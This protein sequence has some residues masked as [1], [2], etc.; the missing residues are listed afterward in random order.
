MYSLQIRSNLFKPKL[1]HNYFSWL[2]VTILH[3]FF[4]F[5]P[6]TPKWSVRSKHSKKRT[7]LLIFILFIFLQKLSEFWSVWSDLDV[8][9]EFGANWSD[10]GEWSVFY[11]VFITLLI[12]Y[13]FFKFIIKN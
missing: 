12:S 11:H 1:Y 10:W 13:C 4:D 8:W 9:S 6:N 7:F 2:L 5:A 3:V